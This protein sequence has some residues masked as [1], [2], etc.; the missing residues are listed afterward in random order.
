MPDVLFFRKRSSC[1]VLGV[2]ALV[3][4]AAHRYFCKRLFFSVFRSIFRC[5]G[6]AVGFFCRSSVHLGGEIE[7]LVNT[8]VCKTFCFAP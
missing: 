2:I 4:A 7:D 6:I 3:D 8:H 5:T 1:W